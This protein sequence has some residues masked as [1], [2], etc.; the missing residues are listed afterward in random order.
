MDDKTKQRYETWKRKRI[1]Q[2]I[3]LP[4]AV[5]LGVVGLSVVW[6]L[7]GFAQ[8]TPSDD[9]TE[10]APVAAVTMPDFEPSYR[11]F[12][13]TVYASNAIRQVEA[14][15]LTSQVILVNKVFQL[16]EAF[17]PE[18][19]TVPQVLTVGGVNNTTRFLQPEASVALEAMFAAALQEDELTLWLSTGY[20]SYEMQVLVHQHFVEL[21]GREEGEMISA[22]PGHC[23][24]QTGLAVSVTAASVGGYLI[25]ELSETPEGAWLREHAHR[26]GFIM[27]YPDGKE[28]LTGFLY[29]PWSL[30]YVGVEAATYIVENDLVLEQYVL[31]YTLS[32]P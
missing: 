29:E 31:P 32:R 8:Q 17:S 10:N 12:D 6:W 22:R 24:H 7:G 9:E 5:L 16:P 2:R 23:E 19:M 20:L 11:D 15:D 28:A 14:A 27:R 3:V 18:E 21:V 30:R 4:L 25:R 1:R 26:F 13:F